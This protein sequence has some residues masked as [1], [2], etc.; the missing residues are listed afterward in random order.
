[1]KS[2]ARYSK[3]NV[4]YLYTTVRRYR[5]V[6]YRTLIMMVKAGKPVTEILIKFGL[7]DVTQLKMAFGKAMLDGS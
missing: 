2:G 4:Y 3:P 1:M 7:S 6:H 5:K